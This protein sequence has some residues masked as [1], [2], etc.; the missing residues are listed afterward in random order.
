MHARQIFYAIS[1]A[2]IV[3]TLLLSLLWP[4]VLWAFVVIGPLMAI[5]IHDI[6][7]VRRAI[8]RNFPVIGHGRYLLEMVRPEIQQYF[9]ESN[10]DGRPFER[11]R[12]SVVYQ[13]AKSERD[14]TPFGTQ[15]DVYQIGYEWMNHSLAPAKAPETPPRIRIG[16]PDCTQP[17]DASTLNISA[18]S[19]GS[20]SRNAVMALNKG[21]KKG[22]FFHN[23]GE[24]S[25]SPYHLEHGGDLCWQIGT[26]YFGCRAADG[27]FD[28]ALFKEVTS[29][30][31]IKMIEIKLSQGAKPGHGGIL[32]AAKITPE[33]ARIR[34]VP[35]GFDVISPPSHRAFS[36]PIG[37]CE[38]IG[39]LRELSGGKPVGFKLCLGKR[40]EFIAICKAIL[41]TGI[42][43]DFIQVDGGEGGTGA[44]PLEFT[45]RLGAPLA[46]SLVFVHNAL[47]GFNLRD[48]IKIIA[49]GKVATGFDMAKRIAIGADLCVAARS[50]MFS[51]GCIQAL[52]CNANDCP[53]GVATQEPEFVRGLDVEDKGQRAYSYQH[54]TVHSFMEL[55]AASG[56]THPDD[57][58]PWHIHRR[59][60]QFDVKHYGE[61][62]EYLQAGDL[63]ADELPKTFHRAVRAAQAD[64]WTAAKWR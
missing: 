1:S 49:S 47:I 52:R 39:E 18:M 22:G 15:L 20:L 21:A 61:I 17:Y 44:A 45:D 25:V 11:A 32:P 57:L 13:R 10:I 24:G 64:N 3:T 19:F 63:L 37:L 30:P 6:V 43:P 56:L 9:V 12:R 5:G 16:G 42:K 55:I 41:Q 29:A 31:S 54:H 35:M 38:F 8:L 53:T 7:Q 27:G 40:R 58:R 50:F 4:P 62:Y 60:N 59:I 51:V 34:G 48:D 14:T 26:G 28:A 36:T 2:L 23:T 33:I 46:E